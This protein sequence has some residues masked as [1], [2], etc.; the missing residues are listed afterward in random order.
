MRQDDNSINDR[1][2]HGLLHGGFRQES[3]SRVLSHSNSPKI[4][5]TC[6]KVILKKGFDKV[7]VQMGLGR[8]VRLSSIMDDIGKDLWKNPVETGHDL[9]L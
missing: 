9:N 5:V 7:G 3:I 8:P 2:L 1:R 6:A 4:I